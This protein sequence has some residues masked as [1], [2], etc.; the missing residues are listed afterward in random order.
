MNSTGYHRRKL[1]ASVG[2][3][4]R[5][6]LDWYKKDDLEHSV[7]AVMFLSAVKMSRN[8]S[9]WIRVV[10]RRECSM[11]EFEQV[12]KLLATCTKDQRQEIFRL[13][14]KEFPIHPIEAELNAQA[15]VILE[16]IHKASDL[17]LRGIRGVIAQATFEMN[18]AS[19]L[20]GFRIV[21]IGGDPPFDCL[22][23]DDIGDVKIQVKM[24]R[25]KDHRP[26]M[27]D[28]AYRHLPANKYVVETQRTRGGKDSETGEDTR[29]Y[30]FGE[31]DILAVSFH[32][33]TNDWSRFLY[34]VERWL[35]PSTEDKTRLS[36]FQ[37]VPFQPDGDWTDDLR[38]CIDWFRSSTKKTIS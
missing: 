27:A 11:S 7:L 13:L 25:L 34:T 6:F 10:Q 35:I 28:Q 2:Y 4:D 21:P 17:T 36:K 9:L 29:P 22:M 5:Q 32:P 24:Q 3:L 16:A 30:K 38:T 33:S 23:V 19:N 15:E 37:P 1:L 18:I 26:M 8:S 14:R 31:F 20:K 12:K